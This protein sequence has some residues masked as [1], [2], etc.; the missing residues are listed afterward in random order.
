MRRPCGTS[1]TPMR[2]IRCGGMWVIS[3][4]LNRMRPRCAGVSPMMERTSVVL[5]TPLRP[6]TATTSPR[7][8][9]QRHPLQ[10]V[11]RAVIGVDILDLQHGVIP[12]PDRFRSLAGWHGWLASSP[13]AISRPWCITAMRSASS[14]ATSMSCSII[15]MVMSRGSCCTIA[16]TRL[17]SAGERPAVGSSSSSSLGAP[18]SASTSSSWRCSP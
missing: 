12:L 8:T 13:S 2:A 4:S 15:R 3:V 9:R 16:T 11:A 5:P 17:V 6:M 10:D 14:K 1:P 7:S 18:A